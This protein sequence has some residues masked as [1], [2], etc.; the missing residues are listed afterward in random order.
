RSSRLTTSSR[1]A[2]S[3]KQGQRRS[4]SPAPRSSPIT[5]STAD[6]DTSTIGRSFAYSDS[7]RSSR[8]GST[9]DAEQATSRDKT[10]NR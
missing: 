6:D 3:L 5:K 9:S 10:P 1:I 2:M 4:L 7:T 8:G